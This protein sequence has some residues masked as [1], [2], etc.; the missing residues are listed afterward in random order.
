MT[1]IPGSA[2]G[3]FVSHAPPR[4]AVDLL[5]EA[6]AQER[7][8][9]IPEAIA[10]YEAAI[11]AAEPAGERAVCAEA[12][13]PPRRPAP[14]RGRPGPRGGAVPRESPRGPPRRQHRA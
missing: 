3:P 2:P 10:A 14:P 11:A 13:P 5:H 6:R 12:P 1:A 4:P 9:R 7:S 8:A